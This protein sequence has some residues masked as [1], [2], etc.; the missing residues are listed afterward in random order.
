MSVTVVWGDEDYDADDDHL[1]EVGTLAQL[2]AMRHD[3]NGDGVVDSGADAQ[4]YYAAFSEPEQGMGCAD[5][6][7]GYE[8]TED[9]DFD[10]NKN[11]RADAGDAYW[12]A[13]KGWQPIGLYDGPPNRRGRLSGDPFTGVFDGNGHTVANLFIDRPQETGVG[14]FGHISRL[15]NVGL[16]NVSVTGKDVVSGLAGAGRRIDRCHVSGS[17]SGGNAVGGVVGR[18][19]DVWRSYASVNVSG[20]SGVG[21]LAGVVVDAILA[22]Y[23]TGSVTGTGSRPSDTATCESAG[24]VGGLVGNLCGNITASYATGPVSGAAAV[25]GLVGTLLP[26]SRI[27]SGYWD[28]TTSEVSVGVGADDTDDTGLIDGTESRT[29]GVAGRTAAA[30]QAPTDY[31][32]IFQGWNIPVN[33]YAISGAPNEP[34][35]FGTDGQYPAVRVDVDGDGRATW[36]EFGHQLRASPVLT[37]TTTETPTQVVLSWTGT[38]GHWTPPPAVTYTLTRDNGTTIEALAE[39]LTALGFHQRYRTC[40]LGYD[41]HLPSGGCGGWRRSDAQC[42]GLGDCRC[43]QPSTS[44]GGDA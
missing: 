25:G 15:R 22:S 27:D 17:V 30:L 40:D 32:G 23:A 35:D 44:G 37:A 20:D 6:C 4:A 12:H 16:V 3:L 26:D 31:D 43:G 9:L 7:Y 21:G 38:A 39:D 2:D 42:A 33:T 11:G 5:D 19:E 18:A 13:G 24:G 1:I 34:W 36:Q 28:V 14:L 8:L 10:T 41:V 29:V